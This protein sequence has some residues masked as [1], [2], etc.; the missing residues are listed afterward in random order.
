MK[1]HHIKFIAAST[2]AALLSAGV[3]AANTGGGENDALGV[4]KASVSLGQAVTVAENHA[5]GK[6]SKAEF[7]QAKDGKWVYDVEVVAHAKVY[8]VR[9]DATSAGVISSTED[10]SDDDGD[11]DKKD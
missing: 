4:T 10:R 7:E 9:V 1:S 3:Y 6:A 11:H 8:D 5:G 2:V